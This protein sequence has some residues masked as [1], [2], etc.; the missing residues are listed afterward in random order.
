MAFSHLLL[1]T[2]T[3]RLSLNFYY[4]LFDLKAAVF[5]F[6]FFLLKVGLVATFDLW[7]TVL[8]WACGVCVCV[9]VSVAEGE[10]I[11]TLEE[12]FCEAVTEMAF[13]EHWP[14]GFVCEVP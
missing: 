6:L 9:C 4:K 13:A 8:C 5:Y 1:K 2:I 7:L 12:G 10:G 14:A 3:E 11:I